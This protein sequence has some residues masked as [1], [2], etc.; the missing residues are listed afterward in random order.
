MTTDGKRWNYLAVEKWS[1]L[2]RGITSNH[3]LNIFHSF[4][5]KNKL[6]KH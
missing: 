1:A 6:K 4:T 5:T 3:C 2:L